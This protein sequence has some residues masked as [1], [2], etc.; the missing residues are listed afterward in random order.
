MCVQCEA[1][2][3]TCNVTKTDCMSCVVSTFL[4]A[5]NVHECKET[6][7]D[8]Y[9][10]NPTGDICTA[11][12]PICSKCF[13]AG[14]TNCDECAVRGPPQD[15]FLDS[16]LR[17]C[18]LSCPGGFYEDSS[19]RV[20]EPCV[21]CATCESTATDCSTVIRFYFIYRQARYLFMRGRN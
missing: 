6:C 1:N 14:K 19:S 12:D 13:G 17:D 9:W 7:I 20:C 15:Y 21:G 2:C 10:P 16:A 3:S 5:E 18:V 8:G 4:Q 11:C